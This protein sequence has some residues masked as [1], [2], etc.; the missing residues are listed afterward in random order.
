MARRN[1][2]THEQLR[3]MAIEAGLHILQQEG[4]SNFSARKVAKVIGYSIGTIYNLFESHDHFILCINART[5]DSMKT[6]IVQHMEN[7]GNIT[8]TLKSLATAYIHFAHTNYY[9]WSALF[10]HS[11][12]KHTPLP[13]WFRHKMEALYTLVETPLLPV[14]AHD[15]AKAKHVAQVLWAGVHGICQLGLTGK[16]DLE[17]VHLVIKLS[18][19]LMDNYLRGLMECENT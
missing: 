9:C 3:E 19:N 1:D 6:Y 4:F 8:L 12:P 2:H 7:K 5:L 18:D 14:L 17:D 11:L 13:T 15:E 16:L 10:K